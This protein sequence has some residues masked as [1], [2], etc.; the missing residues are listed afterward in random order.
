MK[1]TK[2]PISYDDMI[3]NRKLED[4]AIAEGVDIAVSM[5]LKAVMT[6]PGKPSSVDG[7]TVVFFD[8]CEIRRPYYDNL[9]KATTTG[10]QSWNV[11]LFVVFKDR[12][13]NETVWMPRWKDVEKIQDNKDLVEHKNKELAR[14]HLGGVGRG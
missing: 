10:N 7:K 13:G 2:H 9:R 11:G 1:R 5:P 14:E 3:Q 12:G 8:R 6:P 4:F